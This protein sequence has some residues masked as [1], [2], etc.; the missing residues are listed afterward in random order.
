MGQEVVEGALEFAVVRVIQAGVAQDAV[1]LQHGAMGCDQHRATH[2]HAF[3]HHHAQAFKPGAQ[4]ERHRI[5]HDG[6]LHLVRHKAQGDDVRIIRHG[7]HGLPHQHQ[8]QAV[9]RPVPILEEVAEHLPAAL[10]FVDPAGIDD[11]AGVFQAF[12]EGRELRLRSVDPQ[13]HDDPGGFLQEGEALFR[14]FPLRHRVPGDGL[15]TGEDL[16][17]VS[18][19]DRG[20]IVHRR[21][22]HRVFKAQRQAAGRQVIQVGHE[23]DHAIIAVFPGEGFDQL[24][25]IGAL[26]VDP[27]LLLGIGVLR[28]CQSDLTDAV[29]IDL[30]AFATDPEA[31]DADA[32]DG[33]LAGLV[34]I[35]PG[36]VVDGAGGVDGDVVI[37]GEDF[38]DLAAVEFCAAVDFQAVALT[39]EC[40]VGFHF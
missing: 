35:L 34:L 7:H 21:D 12:R 39:Y 13:A 32:V 28:V 1:A 11:I 33:F 24:R 23:E 22:Q 31:L 20:F 30:V 2:Q 19:V 38:G 6:E 10:G 36:D 25:A 16:R 3:Q 26:G 40:D 18:Q 27:F 8:L 29:E 14:E 37:W 4:Q 15:R 17:V 9:F 5:L